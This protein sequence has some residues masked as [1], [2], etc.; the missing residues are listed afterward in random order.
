MTPTEAP[1]RPNRLAF[2]VLLA[3]LLVAGLEVWGIR[4]SLGTLLH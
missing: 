4:A 2:L 3:T 1:A